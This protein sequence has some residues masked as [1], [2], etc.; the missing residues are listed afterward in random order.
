[1]HRLKLQTST[2]ARAHAL[3]PETPPRAGAI[4]RDSHR[5][6]TPAPSPSPSE[7]S[8]GARGAHRIIQWAALHSETLQ[9]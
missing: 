2:G 5:V 3:L 7:E 8:H 1:M 9:S 4:G 6:S